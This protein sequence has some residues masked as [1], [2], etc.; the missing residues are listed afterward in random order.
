MIGFVVFGAGG[1]L[2]LIAL[3]LGIVAAAR[4][5]VGSAAGGLA[6]GGFVSIVFLA[7]AVPAMIFPSMSDV[8]TDTVNAPEFLRAPTFSG[9]QGRDMRYPGAA[10]ADRQ[11]AAYPDIT[12]LR[13]GTPP[14]DTFRRAAV[15]ANEMPN[16]QI[17][18]LDQIHRQLEGVATSSIFRFKDDFTV[19]VRP[20][21]DGSLV[22]MR[23]KSRH[24]MADLGANATRIKAF[25]G[26]LQ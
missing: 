11:R 15:A 18:R 4:G 24:G 20:E 16:W 13:L 3:A 21:G 1:L 2:G 23:S 26:K 22:Q 25:F 9:N 19:E 12:P 5:G 10:F 17:T 7:L 14:D 6:L 8:T